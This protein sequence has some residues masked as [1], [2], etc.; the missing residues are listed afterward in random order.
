MICCNLNV[1]SNEIN[2]GNFDILSEG[3]IIYVDD[4]NTGGPW[5]GTIEHPYKSINDGVFNSTEGDTIFVFNGTYYENIVIDKRTSLIGEGKA[6]IDGMYGNYVVYLNQNS[7]ILKD[8]IIRNSGGFKGDS[9]ILINSDNNLIIDCEIYR[10]KTGIY[11]KDSENNKIKNTIFYSA[12]KGLR[13]KSSDNTQ[14]LD[15][16]FNHNSFGLDIQHSQNF[17]INNSYF[18]TNGLGILLNESS[19]IN[20]SN[21]AVYNNNDNQGGL[22]AY[23]SSEVKIFNCN[24]EHNGF[25]IS[26]DGCS[27]VYITYSDFNLHNHE[28]FWVKSKLKNVNIENCEIYDNIRFGFLIFDG[29]C[30]LRYN[31]FDNNLFSFYAENSI[32][33]AR[34]NWWGSFFA[35]SVFE[36]RIRERVFA[37]IGIIRFLPWLFL[38]NKNAGSNWEIDYDKYPEKI[39][40]SRY[41]QI[42]FNETDTDLDGVPDWWED[43]WGYNSTVWNDHANLD[44]DE[45]AL[46][47]FEECYTDQW[48][49]DPYK[50]DLFIEVDYFESSIGENDSNKPTEFWI[51]EMTAK[52]EEHDIALHVDDGRFGGGE[53]IKEDR[54]FYYEYLDDVYWDYFLHNDLN[55]PRKGIFHYCFLEDICPYYDFSGFS[56]VGWDHLDSWVL[57]PDNICSEFSLVS[58]DRIIISVIMHELGHTMGLLADDH[59]GNDNMVA[60]MPFTKQFFKYSSYRSIMNYMYTYSILDYSEGKLGRNDFDDWGNLDFNFFKNTS[61]VLPDST[62]I[63]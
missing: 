28:A 12:G 60:T 59:G 35:P 21:C 41:K 26:L 23:S 4:D 47:N 31:N 3:N 39:N 32:C 46:N 2:Y 11:L 29:T 58:K 30:N 43:K 20:I 57:F 10:A 14:I 18:H 5:L 45:D 36:C 9:G 40:L 7:V 1:K 54:D 22:M 62:N 44:P 17:K 33:D 15:C 53:L 50:K 52:F 37:K 42:T 6:I 49:S 56:V 24:F 27:N 61:F 16:C 19:N 48:G 8:F 13:S 25:G 51:D 38:K 34:N 55:N 63:I